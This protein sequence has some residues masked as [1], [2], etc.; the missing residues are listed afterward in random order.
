MAIPPAGRLSGEEFRRYFDKLYDA[1]F[2]E[3]D[4]DAAELKALG[5]RLIKSAKSLPREKISN[6]AK[7]DKIVTIKAQ[8]GKVYSGLDEAAARLKVAL[9]KVD[10]ERDQHLEREVQLIEGLAAFGEQTAADRYLLGECKEFFKAKGDPKRRVKLF[11]Q[12]CD[13]FGHVVAAIGK[14]HGPM[15]TGNSILAQYQRLDG[16]RASAFYRQ[17][18][19]EILSEFQLRQSEGN[20]Q[21]KA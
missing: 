3:Y 11:S 13:V 10:E 14:Q 19:D 8:L 5:D 17:H 12:V 21:P 6:S 7:N 4:R 2:A 16:E 20:Q 15:L 1:A 18:R 9:G